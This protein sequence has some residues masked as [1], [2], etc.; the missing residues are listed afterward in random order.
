M[1]RALAVGVYPGDADCTCRVII[2]TLD[3]IGFMQHGWENAF[4]GPIGMWHD[5]HLVECT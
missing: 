3:T 4:S 1:N 2:G 5:V